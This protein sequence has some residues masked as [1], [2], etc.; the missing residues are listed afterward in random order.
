MIKI[1]NN[2]L[3]VKE[4][5]TF[6]SVPVVVGDSAYEIAL[7]H[8]YKGTEE[9]WL[10]YI[11]GQGG[12]SDT[13]ETAERTEYLKVD[14]AVGNT[15][16]AVYFTSEGKPAE[17]RYELNEASSLD[18]SDDPE[19]EGRC[20]MT[21]IAVKAALEGLVRKAVVPTVNGTLIYNGQRQTP[22]WLNLD[23]SVVT[24]SGTTNAVNAGT[25]TTTFTPKEPYLWHDGTNGP[26][27]VDWV[28]EKADAKIYVDKTAI[29]LTPEVLS[30]DIH[31][32]RVGDGILSVNNSDVDIASAILMDDNTL[33]VTG[34]G[35]NS[36]SAM[37]TISLSGNENYNAATNVSVIV[38]ANYL[39]IVSWAAATEIEIANM[40]TAHYNGEIDVADY[41]SVGDIREMELSATLK[42]NVGEIQPAQTL[43]MVIIGMDHDDLVVPKKART[44][45]AITIQVRNVLSEVGYIHSP[46]ALTAVSWAECVRRD[47]C[48]LEFKNAL[49]SGI[50]KL[51]Q[52]V[53]KTTNRFSTT[54]EERA[55][56]TTNETVFL[57]SEWEVFGEQSLRNTEYGALEPDGVQ[58]DYMN[59]LSNHIKNNAGEAVDWWLR[60]SYSNS[61]Y[62]MY[63]ATSIEGDCIAGTAGSTR[64]I[65][66]AFCL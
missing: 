5:D 16:M 11:S 66:P 55:H 51:I 19:T 20:L 18:A 3:N 28:I 26:V 43:E 17:C 40:L 53:I 10:K 50:S 2:I 31:I 23:E 21:N 63:L 24:V 54:E 8:G 32:E 41:W 4:S 37:I 58:Y 48:K 38:T 60:S 14:N 6:E 9:E 27:S 61:T 64:G 7:R 44:R 22:D 52:A 1:V 25:Y 29:E 46:A 56:N 39:K 12:H 34:N 47:W 35:L 62:E 45:A 65:A 49:P 13:V 36:G 57:L 59:A 33:T 42:G 15:K 30:A